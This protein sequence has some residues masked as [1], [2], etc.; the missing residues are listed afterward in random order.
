L[1]NRSKI[2]VIDPQT[3][4]PAVIAEAACCIRAGGVVV[5]PTRSLYG[6]GADALNARAVAS[7]FDLKQRPAA[8]PILV[9]IASS[10]DL[11]PLVRS[12]PPAGRCLMAHFWPGGLTIV[13]EAAP[14][15]PPRLTAG[16]AKIG[17]RMPQ[18]PVARALVAAVGR[19]I[20]GTSANL[21]GHAGGA[22]S[23]IWTGP[24]PG[25]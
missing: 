18:H 11:T 17:I 21:S 23:P 3:P 6:L 4:Q 15:V 2:R 24:W 7:V 14:G 13:F 8:K 5:F 22:G 9:L 16:T 10:A 19:P 25:A 20:T 12:I 1:D